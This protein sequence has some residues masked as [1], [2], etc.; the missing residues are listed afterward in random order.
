MRHEAEELHSEQQYLNWI[1]RYQKFLDE[2]KPVLLLAMHVRQ[3]GTANSIPYSEATFKSMSRK[4]YQHRS[5]AL[6]M[7]RTSTVIFNSKHADWEC[8]DSE[9]QSIVYSCRSDTESLPRKDDILLSTTY[10]IEKPWTFS[11]MY[12]C[13]LE[14]AEEITSRLKRYKQSSFH[15]LMFP[16]IFVEYE[17]TR[18]I[19]A[20]SVDGPRLKQRI[21]DLEN[22]LEDDKNRGKRPSRDF[23]RRMAEKDCES[24][25]L[26]IDVN[27]LKIGF[28]SLK[29]VLLSLDEH[30]HTINKHKLRPDLKRKN[31]IVQGSK[32]SENIASRIQEMIA[33]IESKIR[34]CEGLLNGMALSIQVEWNYHTRRDA[35]A[36]IIIAQSSQRD[37]AQ[38]RLISLVGMI[39]LPGTFL[40]TLFSMSFFQWIPDNSAEVVSPWIAVYFGL[41]III[42]AATIW[43]WK[44]WTAKDF[45]D[46]DISQD[47]EKG[48][49][50]TDDSQRSPVNNVDR[51][52]DGIEFQTI[53]HQ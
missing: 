28:E 24:T 14:F 20:L 36:T 41:T 17:R 37:S 43:K 11:V 5:L 3:D 16:M 40:A 32:T 35:K 44:T 12:G 46:I 10:F 39:F 47:V 50:Y 33:E 19:K 2:G 4:M 6:A 38:M 45:Q 7:P 22:R 29:K 49:T 8:T 34:E 26:W 1:E 25:R 51:N 42:T 9:E 31:E 48:S 18:F 21:M 53:I 23:N 15:P 30:S 13:P 27:S 52:R